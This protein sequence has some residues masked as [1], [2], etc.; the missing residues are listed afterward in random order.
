MSLLERL[1]EH[2]E[3]LSG[4][5][6]NHLRATLRTNYRCVKE[7]LELPSSLFYQSKL[8]PAARGILPHPKAPYPLVFVCSSLQKVTKCVESDTSDIEAR[9]LIRKMIELLDPWPREW[10]Y[11]CLEDVCVMAISRRQVINI[12]AVL[13][14]ALAIGC[15]ICTFPDVDI[16]P[17][18][19]PKDRS[20]VAEEDTI[21]SN[22]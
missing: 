9:I 3:K 18:T 16:C 22:L 1:L 11:R 15:E 10:R 13:Q 4:P 17:K 20:P 14:P 12:P 19:H 2:Y 8:I 21:V 6:I 5:D 7:I